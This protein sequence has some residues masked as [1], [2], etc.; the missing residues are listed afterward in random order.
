MI[1]LR[2][3][4]EIACLLAGILVFAAACKKSPAPRGAQ[5]S[6]A[7]VP[8]QPAGRTAAVQQGRELTSEEV[9]RCGF[10]PVFANK[11]FAG[12]RPTTSLAPAPQTY[13]FPSAATIN[14]LKVSLM[15]ARTCSDVITNHAEHVDAPCNDGLGLINLH[16]KDAAFLGA[17]GARVNGRPD[18]CVQYLIGHMTAPVTFP[19]YAGLLDAT[20]SRNKKMNAE[21]RAYWKSH[22]SGA[23]AAE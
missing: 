19:K 3:H 16:A 14:E 11:T 22:S 7:S 6:S 5:S 2:K 8:G 23:Q 10:A 20:I 12:Y 1:S 13:I 15:L 4:T 9:S 21:F 17:V 18:Q